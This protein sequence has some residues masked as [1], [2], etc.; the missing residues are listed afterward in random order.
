MIAAWNALSLIHGS[1]PGHARARRVRRRVR[2]RRRR[3]DA[4]GRG[5]D[6][7][8]PARR[9]TSTTSM[10]AK[11]ATPTPC[12]VNA[13]VGKKTAVIAR[14][15]GYSEEFGDDRSAPRHRKSVSLKLTATSGTL[16]CDDPG[17][18]GGTILVD[19]VDKGKA[20][21]HVAIETAG[22][23][24][25]VIVK[26]R[27]VF[28]DFVKV[29]PGDE[30]IVKPN[31]A[32]PAPL[33][34][35]QTPRSPRSTAR[36]AATATPTGN[37]DAN[38]K[39]TK[40]A[41]VGA[42]R[43]V[44]RRRRRVRGR[45]P[46]VQVRQPEEPR[47]DRG[48][49]RPGPGRPVDPA[50]ADAPARRRSTCAGCRSTPRSGSARTVAPCC[51]TRTTRRPARRRSGATS[52]STSSIA[53]S[54]ATPAPSRSA[55]GSSATSSSTTRTADAAR[56]TRR[57]YKSMR[58]GVRGSLRARPDRAV[59]A[60]R[61]P[62]SV[63]RGRARDAVLQ[64]RRHRWR[65]CRRARRR[66]SAPS[67]RGSRRRSSTTAG[68]SRA[69]RP[70]RWRRAPTGARDVDRG[71]LAA[72]S[73]CR[74]NAALPDRA[75]FLRVHRRA[76]RARRTP[77]RTRAGC[78]A[79]RRRGTSAASADRPSSRRWISAGRS[80]LHHAWPTAE[81]ELLILGEAVGDV[82]LVGALA[83]RAVRVERDLHAAEVGDVLAERELAVDEALRQRLE[84]RV[85]IGDARA[86]RLELRLVGVAATSS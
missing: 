29:D 71:H 73:G 65:R 38:G 75:G 48:R 57:D 44:D 63:L 76:G 36:A 5:H 67:S 6:A 72:R 23:H 74:T 18:A 60:D 30:Y 20:P 15:D 79:R 12:S 64:G 69:T 41:D 28:D 25:V 9:S 43:H 3:P 56:G 32:E 53:G 42:A 10:P 14:K 58:I 26:G 83:Q 33:P 59:R 7:S 49:R 85:L 81:E 19:D 84:R 55:A 13:P 80:L 4:Q 8:R 2:H 35:K 34:P 27:A 68:G 16:V 78:G 52:R 21:A 11:P 40:H 54:S 70:A 31:Q 45:V 62:H 51:R 86:L 66:C 37:D 82:L 61:G 22:H 77:S 39:V 46:P 1:G 47:A 50:V 17:L 24:V